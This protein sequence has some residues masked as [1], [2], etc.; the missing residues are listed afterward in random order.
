M[1]HSQ[2]TL[3]SGAEGHAAHSAL[4]LPDYRHVV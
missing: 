4:V 3:P 2:T 1:L